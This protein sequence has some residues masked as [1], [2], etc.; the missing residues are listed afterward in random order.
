VR[1][2]GHARDRQSLIVDGGAVAWV[3]TPSPAFGSSAWAGVTSSPRLSASMAAINAGKPPIARPRLAGGATEVA[4]GLHA[5]R[6]CEYSVHAVAAQ[7]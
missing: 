5:S 2:A 4:D 6:H 1:A 3:A 7:P